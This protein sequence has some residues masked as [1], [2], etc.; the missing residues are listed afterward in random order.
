VL[1]V[2]FGSPTQTIMKHL[3][4]LFLAAITINVKAQTQPP[5]MAKLIQL[6]VDSNRTAINDYAHL[7]GFKGEPFGFPMVGNTYDY[8]LYSFASKDTTTGEH[9]YFGYK[10]GE[11]NIYSPYNLIHI[12]YGTEEERVFKGLI[13]EMKNMGAKEDVTPGTDPG[14]YMFEFKGLSISFFTIIE[15]NRPKYNVF[16]AGNGW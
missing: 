14:S 8:Q 15:Y 7:L 3:L 1:I 10:W 5:T 6:Y 11:H 4:L 9:T 16:V 13:S 2:F 12:A